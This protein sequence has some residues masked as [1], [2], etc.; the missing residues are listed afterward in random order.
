[1]SAEYNKKSEEKVDYFE[2]A[3]IVGE[4]N[5]GLQNSYEPTTLIRSDQIAEVQNTGYMA[6]AENRHEGVMQ[7]LRCIINIGGTEIISVIN[8]HVFNVNG[9]DYSET[10]MTRYIPGKRP[11]ILGFLDSNDTIIFGRDNL[12]KDNKLISPEHFDITM[13][14]DGVI[15]ISNKDIR[16]YTEVF[17]AQPN[18]NKDETI[19][20][21]AENLN[22]WCPKSSDAKEAI[23]GRNQAL[24]IR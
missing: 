17:T 19:K 6:F 22:V 7:N 13:S 8:A 5:Y 1:M 18:P 14:T 24:Y 3:K 21:P 4:I 10:I 23:L 20:N 15:G 2:Q 11:E 12:D 9:K 16:N